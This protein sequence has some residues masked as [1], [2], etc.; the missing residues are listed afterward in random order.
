MVI[1]RFPFTVSEI[2]KVKIGANWSPFLNFNFSSRKFA[3]M[4]I[5]ISIERFSF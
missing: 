2:L 4:I 3:L 1:Y 5:S